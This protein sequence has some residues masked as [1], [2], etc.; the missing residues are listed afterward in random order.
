MCAPE[1]PTYAWYRHLVISIL[2]IFLGLLAAGFALTIRQRYNH[3]LLI[4]KRVRTK[5][6]SNNHWMAYY[7]AITVRMTLGVARSELDVTPDTMSMP[8]LVL[9]LATAVID[10]LAMALVCGALNYQLRHRSGSAMRSPHYEAVGVNSP[11]GPAAFAGNREEYVP[12]RRPVC[13][14][15]LARN[16]SSV[17]I[18]CE[19]VVYLLLLFAQ[20]VAP[21]AGA[22][23][24]Y[25]YEGFLCVGWVL[26]LTAW[27]LMLTIA[28][29]GAEE[30]PTAKSKT[31][32]VVG[33]VLYSVNVLPLTVWAHVFPAG[34]VLTY[35][36]WTD[37]LIVVDG[38]SMAFFYIFMREEYT[39]AKEACLPEKF[40]QIRRNMNN[41]RRF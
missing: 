6:V 36:S 7:A 40:E 31:V 8:D 30:R 17:L 2:L 4:H 19:L 18:V 29:D 5:A 37:L 27:V 9:F 25:L 24:Q 28:T 10:G 38:C 41:H 23:K 34:C 16:W 26:L 21:D 12:D 22:T 35:A 1:H 13:V 3:V 32:L 33:M 39:R 11:R 15:Y 20:V 14:Q